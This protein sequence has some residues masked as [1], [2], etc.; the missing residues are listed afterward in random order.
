[1]VASVAFLEVDTQLMG[2]TNVARRMT[3][4]TR[5]L[6]ANYLRP[7]YPTLSPTDGNVIVDLL[8]ASLLRQASKSAV[9]SCVSVTDSLFNAFLAT[10]VQLEKLCASRHGD[11]S[12]I[13]S[14]IL[15]PEWLVTYSLLLSMLT[16]CISG[17]SLATSSIPLSVSII[18]NH[19]TWLAPIP[20]GIS[21]SR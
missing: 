19:Y 14:W 6:L 9:I 20:A 10:R 21:S 18:H 1:M 12:K 11:I 7:H 13:S 8:I 17:N 4:A 5:P 15:E 16:L 2:L 3:G